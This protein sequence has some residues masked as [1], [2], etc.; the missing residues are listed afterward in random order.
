MGDLILPS[1]TGTAEADP[2][3][4]QIYNADHRLRDYVTDIDELLVELLDPAEVAAPE[5]VRRAVH[6]WAAVDKVP[7]PDGFSSTISQRAS[8]P[9]FFPEVCKCARR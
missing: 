8:G 1:S 6:S 2:D 5:D 4:G 3:T 7:S 9:D